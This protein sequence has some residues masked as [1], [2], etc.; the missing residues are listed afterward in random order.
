MFNNCRTLEDLNITGWDM[1]SVTNIEYMFNCCYRLNST[2]TLSFNS[3]KITTYLGTFNG[4]SESEN[5]TTIVNY[6]SSAKTIIDDVINTKSGS[7][8]VEKGEE[9]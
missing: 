4:T 8:K 7:S 5:C 6:T 3:D 2:I 1:A 9:I